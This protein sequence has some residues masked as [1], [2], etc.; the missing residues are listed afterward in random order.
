[1][2]AAA[3]GIPKYLLTV[4]VDCDAE[5]TAVAV[6]STIPEEIVIVGSAMPVA[7]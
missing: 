5:T 2:G 6:P 3:N 7:F 4:A 1:V